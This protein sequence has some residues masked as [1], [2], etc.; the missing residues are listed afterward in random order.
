LAVLERPGE[1]TNTPIIY[2]LVAN[3]TQESAAGTTHDK[4]STVWKV[5]VRAGRGEREQWFQIQDMIV[6]ETRKEMIFLGETVMQVSR[7]EA[8][9]FAGCG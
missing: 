1:A 6:E 7:F 9:V 3:V 4:E 5:H 8:R 2:D